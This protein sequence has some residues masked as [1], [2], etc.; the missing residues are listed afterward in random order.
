LRILHLEDD[1]DFSALV[2][3]LLAK[4]GI[5]A[6]L[7]LVTDRSQFESALAGSHFDLVFADYLLPGYTG[8]EALQFA[9]EKCPET[10]LLLL[11][12]TIGEQ[13]AIDS[14]KSGAK[15]YVLKSRLERLVPSV[16]R[17]IEEVE[18]RRKRRKVETELLRRE[19]H[20]QE[21]ERQ[22]RL[23][24]EGSPTPMWVLDRETRVFLEA[25]EAALRHYGYAREEF[26][27][28]SLHNLVPP[29]DMADMIH[30]LQR[31]VE[32]GAP[33]HF[34]LGGAWR[35][36]KKDG[37]PMDVEI[38]WTAICFRGCSAV[39]AM[40]SDITERK[41]IEQ[42]E[43]IL[44]RL[45]QDLSSATCPADAAK[46][47]KS[48]AEKLFRWDAFTLDLYSA[49][50]D[51]IVPLL[52]VDTDRSGHRFEIPQTGAG[53][54][55]SR[56]ARRV[57]EQ[58][59]RL[60]LR[61]EPQVIPEETYM[62]GDT[63]RPSASL[64]LVPIRNRTKVI[65]VLSIQSYTTKAYDAQDLSVL[66]TLADHCGGALERIRAEQALHEL[67][68]QLRQ[69]QKM[70]AI[71]QLAGGV[72]HDF[73]NILTVI[74]GHASL[75]TAASLAGSPARSAQ[76]IVQAADR[77]AAL[78][79]QLLTFGRRQLMQP[80]CLDMNEVVSN[81]TKMLSRILGEDVALQLNYFP[82]RAQIMADGGMLEQVLLN[83][84]VNA[85]DAMPKGGVL[86]IT[87]STRELAA[88]A[89]GQHPEA[90]AGRFICLA[91]SDSGCG[92][93]QGD[94]PRVFE[95]FFTTKPLGKGTGLGL[96]TVYGIVKQHQGWVEVRSELG[97]G[98]VF[99]VF[100]PANATAASTGN[101]LPKQEMV[102]GGTETILVVEDEGPVREL[103]CGLLAGYGYR[104]V[105]AAS[106]PK[107]LELWRECKATVDL[108]LTDL[109]MP[110]RMN[111]QELAEKLRAD[112]PQLKVLFT[113]GYSAEVIGRDFGVRNRLKYLQ[114]PYHP[115][116]LARAVR[117]CLDAKN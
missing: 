25:N 15:D 59:G 60:I 73:N 35:H 113:S 95:P 77:A 90:Q 51:Q 53:K 57:I 100:L 48:V 17:A 49:E 108:L 115:R 63:S 87:I 14:L 33:A 103:V 2:A 16:Q 6:E 4:G 75:L 79:R 69:V 83:L 78:T 114:K 64:A 31:L 1:P 41:R 107:A 112:R 72:A 96:A 50:Q 80:R 29:D 89:L 52:N 88:H 44:S 45:G 9:R 56:M 24:F 37:S 66:Q 81:M 46:I 106:G 99:E 8:L 68:Q 43:A 111:G 116:K 26:L 61:T 92:I 98:S 65:G 55:P 110:D 97:K 10:P 3:A 54:A 82:Q 62:I 47:I 104:V 27:R 13:A 20:L 22:Y 86:T 19:Q 71:G 42:R 76:Q 67:E 12:G 85:R 5:E 70:E 84:V 11:S 101:D 58:G 21:S 7:V 38:K 30:H 39:L 109:I 94:L 18:E 74:H 23:I 36:H 105:Q 102:R 34:G 32:L 93:S 28:L 117:D 91:V 40:V